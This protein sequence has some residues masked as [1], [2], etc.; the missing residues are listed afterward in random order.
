MK[1]KIM[2][3]I[4][5]IS[6]IVFVIMFIFGL[7]FNMAEAKDCPKDK[8]CY[9]ESG[10]GNYN[11]NGK[12]YGPCEGPY[13]K[14]CGGTPQSPPP[15]PPK[16]GKC[17]TLHG[18]SGDWPGLMKPHPSGETLCA[19]NAD[20][21]LGDWI[22]NR[23]TGYS[24]AVEWLCR[25]QAKNQ[26]L[27][28]LCHYDFSMPPPAEE[29][30]KE[31]PKK[32]EIVI[33]GTPTCG[34][35]L[36][37]CSSGSNPIS[38]FCQPYNSNQTCWKC[39]TPYNV[40][41]PTKSSSLCTYTHPP[42][43]GICSNIIGKCFSRGSASDVT[44]NEDDS[45]TWTCYGLYGG[46][47]A[48]C[49]IPD[50]LCPIPNTYTLNNTTDLVCL[51]GATGKMDTEYQT[52]IK[53]AN[54]SMQ[55]RNN[56]TVN[57]TLL[58]IS[59]TYTCEGENG[60]KQFCLNENFKHDAV[61]SS[62]QKKTCAVGTLDRSYSRPR[63]KM[64]NGK[65]EQI[66]YD[67]D[68]YYYWKCLGIN[69]EFFKNKSQT[70]K[71]KDVECVLQKKKPLCGYLNGSSLNTLDFIKYLKELRTY[72]Y[73]KTAKT[74]PTNFCGPDEQTEISSDLKSDSNTLT[75]SCSVS[76]GS[77]KDSVQCS[78]CHDFGDK[79]YVYNQ[80]NKTCEES[81][82]EKASISVLLNP[83]IVNKGQYCTLRVEREDVAEGVSC[84]LYETGNLSNPYIDK[85]DDESGIQVGPQSRYVYV[86]KKGGS[87]VVRSKEL[88][89]ALNPVIQ[90]L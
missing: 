65:W 52:G 14:D 73:N 78:L 81:S 16:P 90:E 11:Y 32:E 44:I 23:G 22:M 56:N 61:C 38:D 18:K 15:P 5:T 55:Q 43:N 33:P 39:V 19:Y 50:N 85:K 79:E 28:V 51:K 24:Y 84:N 2:K 53:Y 62:I 89:C 83:A 31:E 10:C 66:S 58:P 64:V 80:T 42:E 88:Y 9:S 47:N 46:S 57:Q 67:D 30:K 75:W 70:E 25:G 20:A 26:S 54:D 4:L 27:D 41:Y 8:V 59:V 48:Y 82:Q 63:S 13:A 6:G 45:A 74:N 86:C 7:N 69:G 29:P 35:N 87:E 36:R 34:S 76:D 17:G 37:E 3:K 49:K 71:A 77:D 72:I 12:H 21:A 40:N 60:I 1:T 68:N